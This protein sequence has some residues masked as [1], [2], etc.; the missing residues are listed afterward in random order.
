MSDSSR[1]ELKLELYCSEH[2]NSKLTMT[3]EQ[4]AVGA[5]SAYEVRVK[6]MVHPCS[7]CKQELYELQ[8]AVSVFGNVAKEVEKRNKKKAEV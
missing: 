1:K 5:G 4:S 3:T 7:R 2:P 8:H 6:I